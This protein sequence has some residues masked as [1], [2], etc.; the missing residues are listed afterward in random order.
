M[1]WTFKWHGEARPDL[2]KAD[3]AFARHYADLVCKTA[4]RSIVQAFLKET[5]PCPMISNL[6]LRTRLLGCS[7]M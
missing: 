4:W 2:E 6:S 7:S 5:A 1:T 3:A